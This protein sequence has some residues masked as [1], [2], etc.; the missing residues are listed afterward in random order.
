MRSGAA[1]QSVLLEIGGWKQKG[2]VVFFFENPKAG[3]IVS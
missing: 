2:S 1:L 3:E